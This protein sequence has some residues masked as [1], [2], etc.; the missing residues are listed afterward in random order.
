M[1]KLLRMHP[2]DDELDLY[3]I[4][5]LSSDRT[6]LIEEHYLAC[7]HCANRLT[8]IANLISALAALQAEKPLL[9]DK[10]STEAELPP[11]PVLVRQRG[12]VVAIAAMLTIGVG[13]G[14]LLSLRPARES[15]IP[16][17]VVMP[18]VAQPPVALLVEPTKQPAPQAAPRRR[19]ARPV[20]VRPQVRLFQPPESAWVAAQVALPEP[21]GDSAIRTAPAIASLALWQPALPKYQAKR[22][23]FRRAVGAVGAPFRRRQS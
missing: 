19:R 21:P 18:A 8:V 16:A 4:G 13:L 3:S 9:A 6:Q 20:P 7:P 1:A 22:N 5:R 15:A 12:S 23:W 14:A 10:T 2:S 17:P 11:R